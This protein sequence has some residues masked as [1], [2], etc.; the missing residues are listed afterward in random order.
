[1]TKIFGT[2]VKVLICP[3]DKL[4]RSIYLSENIWELIIPTWNL[5]LSIDSTL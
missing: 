4:L 1:M 3:R 2:L 5:R